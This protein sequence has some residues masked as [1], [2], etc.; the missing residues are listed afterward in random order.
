MI[1]KVIIITID[2][3]LPKKPLVMY[4]TKNINVEKLV[5]IEIIIIVEEDEVIIKIL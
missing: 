5:I 1:E 3:K 4:Q 2:I